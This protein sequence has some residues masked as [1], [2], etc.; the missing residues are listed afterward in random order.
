MTDKDRL[1]KII[2][3][4]KNSDSKSQ[5][6]LYNLTYNRAMGIVT[7]YMT[8]KQDAED[9][10]AESYYKIFKKIDIYNEKKDF[11]NWFHRI[12]V[13]TA[14]DYIR[15]HKKINFSEK[16]VTDVSYLC[17]ATDNKDMD[18]CKYMEAIQQLSPRYRMVFNL[19]V[20]DGYKHKEIAKILKIKEGTSKSNLTKAKR[21]LK[22][23]FTKLKYF[24][25]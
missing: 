25:E 15:K 19:Y 10:L 7:R 1:L 21:K 8:N 22:E 12:I 13:N 16:E 6:E 11:Y 14:I 23:I 24:D 2:K 4:C 18:Y 20:I 3:L 17:K 9:V 5:F